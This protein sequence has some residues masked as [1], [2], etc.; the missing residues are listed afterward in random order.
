VAFRTIPAQADFSRDRRGP[1]TRQERADSRV[2]AG[3]FCSSSLIDRCV[4]VNT[5]VE[6]FYYRKNMFDDYK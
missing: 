2:W 4:T 3:I 1:W 5:K 6:K